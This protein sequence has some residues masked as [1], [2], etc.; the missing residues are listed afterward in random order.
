M[1]L[2]TSRHAYARLQPVASGESLCALRKPFN[3]LNP[4]H[5]SARARGGERGHR[6]AESKDANARMVF[7]MLDSD[8]RHHRFRCRRES[9]APAWIG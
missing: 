9:V 1:P 2:T 4:Y 8:F 7:R 6:G 5:F 3:T